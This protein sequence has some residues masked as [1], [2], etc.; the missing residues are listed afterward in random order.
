MFHDPLLGGF[1]TEVKVFG[2]V[3]KHGFPHESDCF[4]G[5]RSARL[6]RD[7]CLFVAEMLGPPRAMSVLVDDI[8]TEGLTEGITERRVFRLL[9][10]EFFTKCFQDED[11]ERSIRYMLQFD[12]PGGFIK[13]LIGL[14]IERSASLKSMFEF[15]EGKL[16]Y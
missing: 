5:L 15:T 6:G 10:A 1:H 16:S 9:D 3:V 8:F 7:Y 14:F 13:Y 4:I 2:H 11:L 12:F